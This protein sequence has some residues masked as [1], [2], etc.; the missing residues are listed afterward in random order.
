[1]L[2][3]QLAVLVG[4]KTGERGEIVFGPKAQSWQAQGS[5][6]GVDVTGSYLAVGGS[7][8]YAL[9]LSPS[10][11]LLPEVAI[12]APLTWKIHAV[13]GDEIFQTTELPEG[14]AMMMQAGI[15][16]LLG[17]KSR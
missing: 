9:R 12:A 4:M 5:A 15:G 3:M 17:S 1:M 6:A 16:L 2:D 14:Q 7:A 13:K 10:I 8:G 11:R